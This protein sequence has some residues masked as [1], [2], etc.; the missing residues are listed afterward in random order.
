MAIPTKL[1]SSKHTAT[2]I[3]CHGLGDTGHGW[4]E[5]LFEAMKLNYLKVMCPNAPVAPVTLNMGFKMPSWFDIKALTPGAPEDEAGIIKSADVVKALIEDEIKAGIPPSRIVVGGFSQGGSVALHTLVTY[6]KKLAGCVGLSTF[7]PLHKKIPENF[8]PVNKDTKV[9]LGHGTA[10]PVVNFDFG[11]KTKT[12]LDAFYSD[13]KFNSY[14]GMQ[15]TSNNK[16]LKDLQDYLK[17][18]IPKS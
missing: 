1:A 10:D 8:N 17:T 13:V 3:F 18:V 15:H 14:N 4:C 12:V 11:K 16:E 6:D 5:N 2:L 9:F 7:L